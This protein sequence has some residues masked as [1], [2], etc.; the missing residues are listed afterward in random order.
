MQADKTNAMVPETGHAFTELFAVELPATEFAGAPVFGVTLRKFDAAAPPNPIEAD[1][2]AT[3]A[4]YLNSISPP[5]SYN[6]HWNLAFAAA[7]VF[8]GTVTFHSTF[9]M[10]FDPFPVSL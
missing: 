5:F 8:L 10:R 9:R 3:P 2:G 1:A 6:Q 7:P 4:P